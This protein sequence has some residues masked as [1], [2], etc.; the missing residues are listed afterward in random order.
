MS[1]EILTDAYVSINAVDLSDHVK[2][3]TLTPSV[4]LKDVTAM[5]DVAVRKL[6]GLKD[7]KLSVTFYNDWA[8]GKVDA[9]VWGVYGV[10]TALKFRK[11]KTDAIS[12]TNPEYQFNGMWSEYPIAAEVG[13]E[14]LTTITFELSDGAALVRDVTP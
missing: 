7:A 10:Q 4:T 9:T 2:S 5:G 13:N 6:A 12:A 11:S 3:A 14:A 1:V 8:S